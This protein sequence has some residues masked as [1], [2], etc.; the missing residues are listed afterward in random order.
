[1]S[2]ARDIIDFGAC[3]DGATL[4]TVAIQAAIDACHEAGGGTVNCGP[5]RFLTGSIELK[6]NVELYLA[7]GCQLLGSPRLEDYDDF[8]AA[9]FITEN[10]NEGSSKH[11]I[12]A[13]AADNVS[14]TG[15]G[16][17]NG[18]GLEFYDTTTATSRFFAKPPTPRPR[19]VMFYGCHNVRFEDTSYV[20][21]PCWT[22]WLMKCERVSIH[23]LRVYGDQRMINNDGIDIDACRDVTISDC[24]LKTADDC[25]VVRSVNRVYDV[26]G[27]CENVTVSNCVLDS[28]C[29]GVRVGCPGDGVI[30]NCTFTNLTIASLSNGIIVENPKRYLRD[31]AVGTAD[32]HDIL[33]SHVTITCGREPIRVFIEDGIKLVGVRRLTFSDFRIRSGGAI[34]IDGSPETAIEDVRLSSISLATTAPEPII[35]RHCRGLKLSDVEF[36]SACPP[37]A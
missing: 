37:I 12:R 29:Q 3:P 8:V 2:N 10:S 31:G 16:E 34:R 5:G 36:A 22:F 30:R 17:V 27:V 9:G 26:P 25:L 4:N 33:F 6:S 11:V 14:I 24:I 13:V 32:V 7:A 21:S 28:W 35:V 1:M 19:L 23:R 18:N 20:D 15:P